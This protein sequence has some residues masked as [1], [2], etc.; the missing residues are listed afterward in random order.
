MLAGQHQLMPVG[1]PV[2]LPLRDPLMYLIIILIYFSRLASYF[3]IE[4]PD[5]F[6]IPLVWL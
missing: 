5:V 1:K 6:K 2:M 3:G 4:I